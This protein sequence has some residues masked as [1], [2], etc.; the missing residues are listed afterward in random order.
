[1]S[2]EKCSWDEIELYWSIKLQNN[3]SY[4]MAD[5]HRLKEQLAELRQEFIRQEDQLH[6]YKKNNTY[7]ARR[8]E[9]DRYVLNSPT[10]AN[11][12]T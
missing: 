11:P 12:Q 10:P 1:M 4:Q 3:V 2:R 8:L 7:L 5:I 9:Y 6:E